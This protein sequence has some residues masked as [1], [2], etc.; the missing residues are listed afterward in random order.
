MRRFNLG[1]GSAGIGG[2]EH[3]NERGQD[4]GSAWAPPVTGPPPTGTNPNT[5][6]AS[7]SKAA[8]NAAKM[9]RFSVSNLAP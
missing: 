9:K 2:D 3:Q 7:G 1:S 4:A 5:G 6:E 8:T